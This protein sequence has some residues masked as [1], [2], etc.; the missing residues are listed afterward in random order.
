[1]NQ[2]VNLIEMM[3]LVGGQGIGKSTFAR[4]LAMKDDWFCTI[5]NIMAKM[6]DEF[7]GQNCGGD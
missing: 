2:E 1:M 3:V 5:E 4:Y 7:N 6:R